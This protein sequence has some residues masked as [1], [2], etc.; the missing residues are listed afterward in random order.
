MA[1]LALFLALVLLGAALH[2]ALQR[3]RLTLAAARL[4]GLPLPMAT[5][6]LV[7]A[8]V[9][10]GLAALALLIP[11]TMAA[12]AAGAAVLWM[13]YAAA[14]LRRR[15]DVLDC[16]CDFAHRE[17]PVGTAMILRPAL[18][19]GLAL[20][21]ALVPPSGWTIETPFAAAALVALWLAASELAAL[22]APAPSHRR[23][24]S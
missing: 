13:A 5:L 7:L 20:A 9:L 6:A 18:L 10:E 23:A 22:A 16:G 3:E 4:T 17:K 11:A 21:C 24:H 15:G 12:G 8:G 14:L 1:A 19:A 2:K